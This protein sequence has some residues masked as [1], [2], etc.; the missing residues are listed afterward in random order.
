M[1]RKASVIWEGTF[2]QGSG[3]MSTESGALCELGYSHR[4]CV[5]NGI[6]INLDELIA[7][8]LGACFSMALARELGLCGLSPERIETTVT[9]SLEELAAGWTMTR[10]QLDVHAQVPGATQSEF[11]AAA[12]QAKGNCS[13]ARLLNTN[14]SMTASLNSGTEIFGASQ[15]RRRTQPA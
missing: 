10:I 7:A 9:A 5:E 6:G 8:A 2:R 13:I 1:N 15:G 12:L 4:T 3:T 14:V 11:V